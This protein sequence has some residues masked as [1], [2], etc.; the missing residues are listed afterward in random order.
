MQIID[1][2][3][4]R[5][6]LS[7]KGMIS[8]YRVFYHGLG[9]ERTSNDY[10]ID[11]LGIPLSLSF[12]LDALFAEQPDCGD[13]AL[14]SLSL[15]SLFKGL[16]L[17]LSGMTTERVAQRFGIRHGESTVSHRELVQNFFVKSLGLTMREKIAF[18]LGDPF[19]GES[20]WIGQDT[21]LTVL[22]GIRL[23]GV[24]QLR[25]RLARIADI[26]VLFIEGVDK[27]QSDPAITSREA[28]IIL[29]TLPE[30]GTNRKKDVLRDL[31]LRGRETGTLFFSPAIATPF[32][33]WL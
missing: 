32:K 13:D 18:L 8:A 10:L 11:L 16:Y 9:I 21:L 33:L 24:E 22:T 27:I 25:D 26:G 19:L 20:A 31:F 15:F 17:P 23:I 29:Q 1:E 2:Q 12:A 14:D 28:L 3:V 6:Y 7:Q 4:L 30:V 5:Q